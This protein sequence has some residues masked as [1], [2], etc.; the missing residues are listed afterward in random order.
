MKKLIAVMALAGITSSL[1][2]AQTPT[3]PKDAGQPNVFTTI[4]DARITS[5]KNQAELPRRRTDSYR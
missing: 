4:K 1:A 5:I 3:Q 2:Q